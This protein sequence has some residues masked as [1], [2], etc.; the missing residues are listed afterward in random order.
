MNQ[1]KQKLVFVLGREHEICLAELKAVLSRFDFCFDIYKITANLVFANIENFDPEDDAKKVLDALA[2]TM[3]IFLLAGPVEKEIA[4]QVASIIE[5]RKRDSGIPHQVRDDFSALSSEQSK[6]RGKIN[7]GISYY[8]KGFSRQ[9]INSIALTAKKR[10]KGKLSLRYVESRDS[11]ELSTI[12]T[13]KNNLLGKGIEIGLF[14][15]EIGVLLGFNNPEEWS[16]RDYGKPRSDKYSGMLP[17][18]LAR[19]M[20]NLALG[21]LPKSKLQITNKNSN[22]Q[23]PNELEIRTSDLEIPQHEVLVADPF[24]GSGNVLLE[25]MM[26]GCDVIGSDISPKAVSDTKSN[27][28][29]LLKQ[30]Q[31]SGIKYQVFQ[32][33]ATDDSL[34]RNLKLEIRNY[35]SIAVVCE[36][37][38]GEPKKFMPSMNAAMG[39]Y[40]E[41]KK[42]YLAFL[43][44]CSQLKT[45]NLQLV[46]CLVFPLVETADKGKFSLFS[47]CVDEIKKLGYTQMRNSFV[48]GRDYQIVKREIVLLKLT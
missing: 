21:E 48:Y 40:E 47:E 9:N 25:A 39:E 38:L 16:K 44:N 28:E 19:M 12:L 24:C 15:Q 31:V 29:W 46:L 18:K 32:S 27:I 23:A 10:L 7:F 13:L 2:G 26:L 1:T 35:N 5:N 41:I 4:S 14:D 43:K 3:K 20:I 45:Y 37:F 17:P 30:Y 22:D 36:P 11:A 8:G 34:I 42:L 33:D 6:V